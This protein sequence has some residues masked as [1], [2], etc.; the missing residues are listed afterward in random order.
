MKTTI[1]VPDDVLRQA[2]RFARRAK[3]SRSQLFSEAVREYLQRHSPDDVTPAMNRAV[4]EVQP[5][6]KDASFVALAARRSLLATEW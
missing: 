4:D 5:R 2:D 6:R 1:S 3:K